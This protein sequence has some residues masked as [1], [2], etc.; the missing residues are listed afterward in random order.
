[1]GGYLAA[2]VSGPTAGR[3]IKDHSHSLTTL[4]LLGN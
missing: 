1:M 3:L 4:M 2:R